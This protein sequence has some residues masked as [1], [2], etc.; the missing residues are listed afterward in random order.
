M[1][2]KGWKQMVK[3]VKWRGGEDKIKSCP[4]KIAQMIQIGE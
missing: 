2:K 1:V 3:M 4:G